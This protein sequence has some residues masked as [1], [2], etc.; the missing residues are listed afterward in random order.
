LLLSFVQILPLQIKYYEEMCTSNFGVL[1]RSSPSDAPLLAF[2]YF[3][4]FSYFSFSSFSSFFFFFFFS[5]SF[6]FSFF[7]TKVGRTASCE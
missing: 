4:S 6:S 1:S 5:F 3:S 2:S 7:I